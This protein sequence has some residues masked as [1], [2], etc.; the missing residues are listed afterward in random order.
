MPAV[1]RK[2]N[3]DDFR[4]G[5]RSTVSVEVTERTTF[6][7]VCDLLVQ[8]LAPIVGG[9]AAG[10]GAAG[11]VLSIGATGRGS[12]VVLDTTRKVQVGRLLPQTS[13]P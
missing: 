3:Y 12:L 2:F 13:R 4:T 10:G 5:V 7:E 8:A 11:G 6:L 1:T 9:G